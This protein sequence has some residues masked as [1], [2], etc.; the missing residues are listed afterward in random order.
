MQTAGNLYIF[1]YEATLS[2]RHTQKLIFSKFLCENIQNVLNLPGTVSPLNFIS[3]RWLR[4]SCGTNE[5]RNLWLPRLRTKLVTWPP[6]TRISKFPEPAPEP[7]TVKADKQRTKLK[8]KDW[9]YYDKIKVEICSHEP[10]ASQKGRL[11]KKNACLLSNSTGCP[12]T[13][14]GIRPTW[15]ALAL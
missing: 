8:Q 6:L 11:V 5:A 9:Y 15:I 10:S 4:A 1:R 7:S 2:K 13:P 3:T 14:L 12:S